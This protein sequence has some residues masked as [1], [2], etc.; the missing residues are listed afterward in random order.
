MTELIKKIDPDLTNEDLK[1]AKY[2]QSWY[3]YFNTAQFYE[4]SMFIQ[5]HCYSYCILIIKQ[6]IR[7]CTKEK[8]SRRIIQTVEK[9]DQFNPPQEMMEEGKFEKVTKRIDVWYDGVMVMGTNIMLQWKLWQKT[10]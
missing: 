10:W 9:D 8:N 5:R 1:I 3:N 6:H 7:L 2:S 4:N